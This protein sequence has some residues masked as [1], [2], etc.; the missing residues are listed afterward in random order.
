MFAAL[1]KRWRNQFVSG[2]PDRALRGERGEKLAARLLRKRGYKILYRNFRGRTGGEIDLVCR[3]RD[4]LVFVE[5]KTR[6]S[7]DFGRPIETIKPEQR[8]R[9]ARGA[10][11]WLRM[12]DDPDVLFRF[13]V[14]E[15]I[16]APG[17]EPRLELIKNAFSLPK[18]YL[19]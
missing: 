5:V 3:D 13:D 16:A 2:K 19:Y 17:A 10:L 18:S 14:V 8:E 11:A 9:I 4:T 1:A 12:L 6:G 15:V 7:E